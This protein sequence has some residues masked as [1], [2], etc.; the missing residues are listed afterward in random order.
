[1][2]YQVPDV[3]SSVN[4]CVAA[5]QYV[6][7]FVMLALEAGLV[8]VSF[9]YTSV[10]FGRGS[11]AAAAAAAFCATTNQYRRVFR[12]SCGIRPVISERARIV[13]GIH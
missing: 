11:L 8:N 10:L 7:F 13:V 2:S 12:E 4:T 5:A 3:F 1:M 9:V 6:P